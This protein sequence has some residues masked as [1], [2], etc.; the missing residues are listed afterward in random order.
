MK[1]QLARPGVVVQPNQVYVLASGDEIAMSDHTL[2]AQPRTKMRG[3]SNVVS[4]FLNSL[5]ASSHPAIA[6]ILS[7]MDENGAAALRA[8]KQRGGIAIAQ[9]PETAVHPSMPEAAIRTGDVDSVL[10]PDKIAGRLEQIARELK[11]TG[12]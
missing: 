3:W 8:F 2:T 10:A 4:V 1:V 7:G 6:V 5:T 9:A 11:C 12:H